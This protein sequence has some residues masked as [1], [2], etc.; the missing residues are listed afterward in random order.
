MT[1]SLLMDY[2]TDE[3][4]LERKFGKFGRVEKAVIVWSHEYRRSRG[5]RAFLEC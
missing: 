5:Y 3:R 4:T 2:G 1:F